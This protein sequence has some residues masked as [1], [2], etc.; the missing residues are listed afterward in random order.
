MVQKVDYK[1]PTDKKTA[2]PDHKKLAVIAVRQSGGGIRFFVMIGHSF[3][4]ISAIYN[5]NKRSA[6]VDDMLRHVF[7][8]ASNFYFDDEFGLETQDTIVTADAAVVLVHTAAGI[9]WAAKKR[10][11]GRVPTILGITFNLEEMMV[12]MK[13]WRKADLISTMKKIL[14]AG[15]LSPG[16]AAKLAGK[17]GFAQCHF[18]GK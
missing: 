9:D 12:Q 4:L 16:Q 5:Y 10:Y 13:E 8:V 14:R 17:L 2:R 3:G 6:L 11:V 15:R 18:R 7:E 1:T